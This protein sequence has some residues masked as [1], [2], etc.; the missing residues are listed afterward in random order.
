MNII[1]QKQRS[2]HIIYC[3]SNQV[4]QKINTFDLE[5]IC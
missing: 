4:M 5:T 2:V 1:K 3:T